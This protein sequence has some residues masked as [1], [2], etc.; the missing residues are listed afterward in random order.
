MFT[1]IHAKQIQEQSELLKQVHIPPL[2]LNG[3]EKNT[4]I[5]MPTE[6]FYFLEHAC[7]ILMRL[8]EGYLK[9]INE[10]KVLM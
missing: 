8:H 6:W 3:L 9:S 5:L 10:G 1:G 4:F 7:F 2:E